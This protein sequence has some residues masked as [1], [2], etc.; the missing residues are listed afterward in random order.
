MFDIVLK[1]A[2]KRVDRNAVVDERLKGQRRHKLR[3]IP[4][5][6]DVHIGRR[7]AKIAGKLRS[8]V[9]GDA[10]AYAQ[11]NR[12]AFKHGYPPTARLHLRAC[13]NKKALYTTGP[14]IRYSEI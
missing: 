8:L 13:Q 4:C 6:N 2:V 7:L 12:F 3:R 11:N 5:H 14:C 1:I 10:P 9:C